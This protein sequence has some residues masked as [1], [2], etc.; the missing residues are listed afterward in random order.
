MKHGRIVEMGSQSDLLAM[1]GE[2]A[3]LYKL[4]FAAG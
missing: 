1:D 4:Q 2:F 3:R